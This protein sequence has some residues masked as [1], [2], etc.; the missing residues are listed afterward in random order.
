MAYELEQQQ[1][2]DRL[3]RAQMLQQTQMPSGQMV[4]RH[5]VAPSVTQYLA[6]GLRQYLGGQEERAAQQEMKA[7]AEGRQKA[8]AEALRQFGTMAQGTPEQRSE[9]VAPSFDEADAQMLKGQGLQTV[10]PAQAPNLRG[11][12]AALLNAPDPQLRQA[13]M[14]GM[15]QIPQMEAQAAERTENRTFRREERE[16]AAAARASEMQQQHELR[17]QMLREQNASR[18]QMA[19][20]NR[21]H[22]ENMARLAASLRAPAQMPQA[23]VIQTETGP[24]IL[25]PGS[26]QAV[27]VVGPGGAQVRPAAT[28]SGAAKPLTESQ[29]KGALYLGQMRSATSELDKLPAASPVATAAAGNTWT[30]WATPANAQKVGQLQ[31]QWAEAYLRAKT[32]AAATQGEVDLNRRTFFPVVGDS[33]AVIKQKA[34]MRK[35]AERDMEPTA[36]PAAATAGGVASPA[37]SRPRIRFDAQG[38]VI[39]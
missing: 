28:A 22:Q 3:R 13:A 34:E 9:F 38:N 30:N 10:T 16:A 2:A 8:T 7:L 20:E 23:Q 29:A 31:N 39:P 37:Q 32:G 36:G 25:Q 15:L 35:Q 18:E 33:T 4:G 1:L 19:A 27:P 21:A 5:Y 11:A 26:N 14:Q 12:Y 6:S 24:M 17:L